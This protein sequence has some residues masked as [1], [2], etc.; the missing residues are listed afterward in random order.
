VNKFS[1]HHKGEAYCSVEYYTIR[2]D[3]CM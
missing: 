1:Q 2:N 3:C